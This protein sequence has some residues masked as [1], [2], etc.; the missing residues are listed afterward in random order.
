M[1][2]SMK[3]VAHHDVLVLLVPVGTEV[4][5]RECDHGQGLTLQYP[6]KDVSDRH[7]IS[8]DLGNALSRPPIQ[9]DG[10]IN[11]EAG[12]VLDEENNNKKYHSMSKVLDEGS[13]RIWWQVVL[14][15]LRGRGQV[16]DGKMYTL[17]IYPQRGT[18]L[19]PNEVSCGGEDAELDD[20]KGA[21]IL[22]FTQKAQTR[23]APGQTLPQEPLADPV[24]RAAEPQGSSQDLQLEP[25]CRH[26]EYHTA[27]V[28]S[29]SNAFAQ[30][31][32]F[33]DLFE[34]MCV[35]YV[36]TS[37]REVQFT[38]KLDTGSEQ[39]FISKKR[40]SIGCAQYWPLEPAMEFTTASGGSL[41]VKEYFEPEWAL[42]CASEYLK[43]IF[44][45]VEG[46]ES[47]LGGYDALIGA[48]DSMRTGHV[49]MIDCPECRFGSPVSFEVN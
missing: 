6:W 20:Q 15:Q 45:L 35:Y 32:A 31:R 10:H 38:A 19:K 49:T 12:T 47:I 16:P 28:L 30:G 24:E 7:P 27:N 3:A 25:P 48:W 40:I 17:P 44:L 39:S 22:A 46:D 5:E 13:K 34:R 41:M 21:Y 18:D 8:S 29:L 33:S 42:R 14:N 36:R 26:P 2:S 23:D 1:Q 43:S 4:V 37:N 11:E 9:G